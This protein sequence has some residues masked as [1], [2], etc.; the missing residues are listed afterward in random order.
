MTPYFSREPSW[1]R[2]RG[3]PDDT[4]TAALDWDPDSDLID[5]KVRFYYNHYQE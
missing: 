4:F 5:L 1:S 2:P 3:L